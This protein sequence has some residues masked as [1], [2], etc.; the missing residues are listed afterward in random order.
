MDKHLSKLKTWF[1]SRQLREKLLVTALC[2][3]VIYACF[4]LI[5][6]NRLDARY[7]DI[8]KELKAANDK[9]DIWKSQLNYLAEIPNSKLY[10]EWA[11]ENAIYANVKSKY[12][13]LLGGSGQDK[14]DGVIRT[15]LS[16][17]PNITVVRIENLNEQVFA[18]NKLGSITET[19]YQQQMRLE[20]IGSFQDIVDYLLSLEK[21]LPTIHWD[22]LSY[23]VDNYPYG[24]VEMEFSILY[25]KTST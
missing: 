6:F 4:A 3:A 22:T 23:T 1:E 14:W 19:I 7:N 17:Y 9:N 5:I 11:S 24:Q 15:V 10:K 2:W 20:V 8:A 21:T 16:N 25:E 18:A 12:K 13:N